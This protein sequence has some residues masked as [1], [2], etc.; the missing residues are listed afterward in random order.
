MAS[1]TLDDND[2]TFNVPLGETTVDGNGGLDTLTLDWSSVDGPI[3]TWAYYNGRMALTDDGL[4]T[5]DAYN[6]EIFQLTG[7]VANDDLRGWD[8]ADILKGGSGDDTLSGRLGADLID[9]GAGIHDTWA[10]DYSSF[11]A[12]PIVVTLKTAGAI[13]TVAATSAQIKNIE[14]LSITTSTG[15]DTINTN[16]FIGNDYID[17]DAGDD[18]VNSGRGVDTIYTRDGLDTMVMN[19][20]AV[21]T[22]ITFTDLGGWH[23]RFADKQG[24]QLNI[25]EVYRTEQFNLTGGTGNDYLRGLGPDRGAFNDVLKGGGGNDTLAGY[26]GIDTIEGG[27]GT[28]LYIGDFTN[29]AVA[30]GVKVDIAAAT[31]VKI[32]NDGSGG[33]L[34]SIAGI[35]RLSV[36]GSNGDDIFT[37]KAG[38]FND[39][40]STYGGNDIVTTGRG[41]DSVWTGDGTDTLVMNWGAATTNIIFTDFGGWNYQFADGEGDQLSISEVYKTE[42]FNLTGGSGD[43]YLRGLGADRGAL[44]DILVGGAGNDTLYSGAGNDKVDGGDGTDKWSADVSGKPDDVIVNAVDSQSIAQGGLAG[45]EIRNIEAMDI[46]TGAGNDILS[47]DGFNGNDRV[48]TYAGN[49]T[50]NLG[51]GID[52]VWTGDGTDT[53]IMNWAAATTNI[54]FSDLGSWVYQFANGDGDQLTITDVYRTEQFQLTGGSGNDTLRGL[55]SDRGAFTDILF[56]G[57]GNDTLNSGSGNDTVDGGD[58]TDTWIAD[59]SGETQAILFSASASQ[60]AVQGASAGLALSKIE[61]LNLSTGAGNDNISTSGYVF[62]DIVYT[63]DGNDTVNLGR[64]VDTVNTGG[65]NTGTD[66]DTLIMDWSAATTN[67]TFSDLG[68]WVYQFA[69]GNGDQLTIN[70]A[71]KTEQFRLTG[72]SGDDNLRGLTSDRGAFNDILLGGIG[73]DTLNS[74]SGN[75]TIDGGDGIDTWIADQSAETQAIKF[76]AADSQ[77]TAQGGTGTGLS[78]KKIEILNLS[79]GANNDVISTAGYAGNDTVYTYSGNDSV[80]LGRGFDVAD[81]GDGTDTLTLSMSTATSDISRTSASGWFTYAD[82][83]GIASLQF[84]NFEIFKLTGGSGN[85]SL[86][87]GNN[88]DTLTGG[89]GDDYLE[90]LGS[91]GGSTAGNFDVISGGI[92]NDSYYGNFDGINKTLNLQLDATGAG[93][94]VDAVVPTFKLATLTGIENVTLVTGQG[95]DTINLA[96]VTGDQSI[97]TRAGN[98]TISVGSGHHYLDGGDGT[99]TAVVNFSTS[100]TAITGLAQIYSSASGAQLTDAAGFNTATFTGVEVFNITGGSG[101]DRLFAYGYDDTLLGGAGNDILYGGGGNDIL[102]GGNGQSTGEG[103]NGAGNDIFRYAYSGGQ[104][105]DSIMDATGGD[106][107]KFD[108]ASDG[109]FSS[110]TTGNGSATGNHVIEVETKADGYTYLYFGTN[111]TVGA[112]ITMKLFGTF[113]AATAFQIVNSGHD[114]KVILGSSFSGTGILNGTS[115]NDTITGSASADELYG[116]DGDDILDGAGGN[117]KIDGGMG[118]DTLTGGSGVDTFF[119]NKIAESA[120]GGVYSDFITDFTPGTDKI[121]LSAIDANPVLPSNQAFDFIGTAAFSG[122][123]GELRWENSTDPLIPD[124]LQMDVN[125]DGV[126][127]MEIQL[128]GATT[129]IT[130]ANFIL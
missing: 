43:D 60:A 100:T 101:N 12:T 46:S 113:D 94:L 39:S 67:I 64:G 104:G 29:A 23:W 76:N 41:V 62:N 96:A 61:I 119:Y 109:A 40:F 102:Y 80:N 8:N 120:P 52:S 2:N 59:Q 79:T 82:E 63:Y 18:T 19:W 15:D 105:V 98:D 49:D 7:G 55:A 25:M 86:Y 90:G 9:G 28:D 54:T 106:T 68:S 83:N 38:A 66:T 73:N 48:W 127:D 53:L 128:A 91:T 33:S 47:T 42:Q 16:A 10:V 89:N 108:G 65:V 24:D 123:A 114:L 103:S 37:A 115:G 88:N 17:T 27:N 26:Q 44:N 111:N 87:G 126:P 78:I 130:A 13:F 22:N 50:V 69:D 45:L 6:F 3:R 34:G 107:I 5:I 20:S 36:I 11:T 21:T 56:G 95:G 75:D 129:G 84:R 72:G 118:H 125:G 122:A 4:N 30:G 124:I 93:N 81:G 31:Q 117:D 74:G 77:T 92:G 57:I 121:N 112:D 99:D 32:L 35:E 71:Y 14:Q 70:E 116:K 97:Y 1:F 85:D 58:G 51:R 110:I